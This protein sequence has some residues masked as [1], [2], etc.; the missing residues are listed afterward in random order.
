M[1][2]LEWHDCSNVLVND[3]TQWALSHTIRLDRID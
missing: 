1:C 3:I 2:P